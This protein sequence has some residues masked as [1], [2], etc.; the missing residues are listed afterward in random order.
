MLSNNKFSFMGNIQLQVVNDNPESLL[1]VNEM[2]EHV[3]IVIDSMENDNAALF[4]PCIGRLSVI[5]Q[6]RRFHGSVKM[7]DF[8]I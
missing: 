6:I 5:I 3:S 2:S 1:P 8:E 4:I 7:I